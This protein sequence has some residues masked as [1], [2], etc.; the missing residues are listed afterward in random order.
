MSQNQFR[1]LSAWAG[2]L[3]PVIFVGVFTV[4]GILRSG[5][6]P[7]KMYISALSLSNR[8]W[9]QIS[10]FLIL[11]F[12][13]FIFTLGL[14]KEFQTGKASRGGI[15]TL[16]VISA[17]FFISGPF[18]MDPTETP[19][20]QMSVHGLIHGLSGG[21]VFT[22]MPIIIFIFLRRFVSDANWQ[23]FRWWTQILGIIEAIGVVVF[24]YASKIPVEQNAYIN[25]F[26][27]FQR[28]ALIPFMVWVFLFGIEMLRRQK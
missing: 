2:I 20:G 14:S 9:I 24:T 4:E 16:Y 26:G 15:I 22:I 3:A 6:D 27:L 10:N 19:A 18:V 5:Y 17:L 28:I 11:G 12:L 21:I 7:L 1:K 25:Y 8:G 23:S 13:L